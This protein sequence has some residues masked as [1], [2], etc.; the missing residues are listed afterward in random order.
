MTEHQYQRFRM[1]DIVEE[2][3]VS[4]TETSANNGSASYYVS[5]QDIQDVFPEAQRF[6]LNGHPIPFLKKSDGERIKPL[7]IAFYPDNVLEVI[8]GAPQSTNHTS[9]NLLSSSS[10]LVRSFSSS[11]I[12]RDF[13]QNEII[14]SELAQNLCALEKHMEHATDNK[15]ILQELA[16][17]RREIKDLLLKAEDRDKE[18]FRLQ[19]EVK[20]KNNEMLTLQRKI[21]EKQDLALDRLAILQR[22]AQAILVQTF[23]L[24]EYPIPRLFIILPVDHTKWDPIKVLENKFRLHFLCECGDHT[25]NSS[26]SSQNQIHTARHEGYEIRDSTEFFSKYGKYMLILL[27]ALRIG[28][29]IADKSVPYIHLPKLLDPRI[30]FSISYME[31]LSVNEP[32]LENINTIDDHE[33]LEGADLRQLGTFLQVNDENRKLGNL[34]RTTTD[35]GHV[36]WVCIDHYRATYQEKQ[37]KVFEDA[38]EVNGGNYDSQLG[39]VIIKL[40]SRIRAEG[41]FDALAKARHV[42]DLD[43]TFDWDCSRADLETFEKALKM[44][45]VSILRLDLDRFRASN[46]SKLLSTSTRYEILVRIIEHPK[47]KVVHI[48]L[49]KDFSKLSELQPK[50]S[51]HLHKLSFE[52]VISSIGASDFRVLVQALKANDALTTLAALTLEDNKIGKKGA[53]ALAEALK[54]NTT[55]TFLNLGSNSIGNE[56]AL[57]LAEALKTSITLVI[58]G[59]WGNSIG[60]EGALALS[61]ALKIN[62]TLTALSLGSNSIGDEGA[63]ALAEALKTN[64]TL[65][66][67]NLGFNKIG[68]EGA[69]ALAETLKTNTTLT[70]LKL[71]YNSIKDEGALAMSEALKTNTTL[72]TLD[73]RDNSIG[74]EGA[75]ALSEALKNNTTLTTLDLKDNKI[76]KEGALA[77]AEALKTNTTC[78]VRGTQD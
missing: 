63:L 35:T 70:T 20:E 32:V 40:G 27:Q 43:L 11:L 1:A 25:M 72:T 52:M 12:T 22:H 61:K 13:K 51:S 31:A 49:S 47:M 9:R 33:A 55:L 57:A 65:T 58:L 41:F 74:N 56:G 10:N 75:L 23:E 77:L 42:Y 28:M 64:I 53:L 21:N 60:N 44:S 76:V 3:C 26:K 73:L 48:V 5:L 15:E 19:L 34:Y 4:I 46:T 24:H 50:I 68:G 16:S 6:K 2:V 30:D 71:V 78:T 36:K 18:M 29:E 7:S 39:H 67:L 69:L 37:Q 66:T 62:T 38:V 17:M 54:N 8:T 45:S 14:K 59:L